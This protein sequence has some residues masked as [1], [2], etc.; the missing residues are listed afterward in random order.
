LLILSGLFL[1]A[2]YPLDLKVSGE[3]F[4]SFSFTLVI[5]CAGS[6]FQTWKNAGESFSNALT[7]FFFTLL[8]SSSS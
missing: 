6:L 4:F 2:A 8:K 5:E 3:G 1:F 7:S